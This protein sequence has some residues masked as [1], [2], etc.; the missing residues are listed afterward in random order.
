MYWAKM[1][2]LSMKEVSIGKNGRKKTGSF[3]I[4]LS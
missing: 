2:I 3:K 4:L 1:L